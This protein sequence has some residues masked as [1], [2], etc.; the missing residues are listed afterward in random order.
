MELDAAK[1]RNYVTDLLK[2][3]KALT[4]R[5][6]KAAIGKLFKVK[7]EEVGAATIRQVRKR[8]GI[9]RPR[10][11]AHAKSLLAKDPLV[12][13]KKVIGEVADKF[14]IRIGPP[15]VSRLRSK[16]VK[17]AR[18]GGRVAKAKATAPAAA[19]AAAPV[20]AAKAAPARGR[21]RRGRPRKA[22]PAAAA[23]PVVGGMVSAPAAGRRGR[24]GRPAGTGKG[25]IAVVF[26]GK[27]KP[28]D[29]ATFFL[30]LGK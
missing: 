4:E 6:V 21:R 17:A 5:E 12:Q 20:A 16:K 22:A 29:L 27:G 11:I 1:V 3:N 7:P 24:G 25:D 26:N 8:L 9:D 23:A 15:D 13:A 2:K 14:G 28:Q 19:P 18:R 30:S 10:A